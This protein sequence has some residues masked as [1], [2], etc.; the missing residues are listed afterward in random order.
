MQCTSHGVRPTR[1]K[2]VPLCLDRHSETW[3][4][5]PMGLILR[6]RDTPDQIMRVLG[7]MK[8]ARPCSFGVLVHYREAAL[9]PLK[10]HLRPSF[11]AASLCRTSDLVCGAPRCSRDW[12]PAPLCTMQVG[13]EDHFWSIPVVS[14]LVQECGWGSSCRVEMR[15]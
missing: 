6:P 1:G 7:C 10:T 13:G 9:C 14:V 12:H 15:V 4:E 8:A 11:L 3:R 5:R 2:P